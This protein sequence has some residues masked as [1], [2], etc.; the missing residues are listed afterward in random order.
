MRAIFGAAIGF[1]AGLIFAR[2]NLQP[3]KLNDALIIGAV[4]IVLGVWGLRNYY[5]ELSEPAGS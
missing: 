4:L 1:G 5:G 2:Y 3:D